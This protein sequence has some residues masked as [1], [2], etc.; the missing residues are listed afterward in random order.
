MAIRNYVPVD[1]YDLPETFEYELDGIIYELTFNYIDEGD[2]FTCSIALEGETIVNGWKLILNQPLFEGLQ[3]ERLPSTPLVPM[4]ESG[5]A[6]RCGIDEFCET[7]FLY[8]DTVDPL[9][10]ATGNLPVDTD[11]EGDLDD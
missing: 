9:D 7:V 8:E 1:V 11:F 3:D 5:Q 2:F 6:K 10:I 4:D